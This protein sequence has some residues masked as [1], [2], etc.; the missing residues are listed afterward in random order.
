[1]RVADFYAAAL[2][3]TTGELGK[4]PTP[5][6]LAAAGV[7]T[8]NDDS[9]SSQEATM[10]PLG[11]ETETGA[12]QHLITVGTGLSSLSK[13]L[14]DKI[15]SNEYVD[16]AELP[17]AKGKSKPLPN[18]LEGQIVIVQAADLLQSRQV[19]PDFATWCQSLYAT[20]LVTHQPERLAD[21]Y[22]LSISHRQSQ[23][24][25]FMGRLRPEFSARCSRQPAACMGQ[26]RPRNLCSV[27]HQ[28][29]SF[30]RELV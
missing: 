14:V 16:F 26:G 10:N 23:L 2:Y 1:M 22:G 27:L 12:T 4:V 5:G 9:N 11:T 8:F 29:S 15:K 13:K 3:A 6:D 17:P 28:S 18:I 21:F 30:H 24:E 19:I 20:V 25:I 7:Q